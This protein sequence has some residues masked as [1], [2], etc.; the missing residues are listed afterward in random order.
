MPPISATGTQWPLV[1]PPEA[2]GE[3]EDPDCVVLGDVELADAELGD[4]APDCVVLGDVELA[5]AGLEVGDPEVVRDVTVNC[6][7][8]MGA[9]PPTT[10]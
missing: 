7:T 6:S 5:D 4:P 2:D 10:E 9:P 3:L 8:A 1:R